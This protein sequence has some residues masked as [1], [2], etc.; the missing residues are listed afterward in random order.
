[1]PNIS[2]GTRAVMFNAVKSNYTNM[3]GYAYS[4]T[5]PATGADPATGTYLGAV[6]LNGGAFTPGNAA[7]GLNFEVVNGELRKPPADVWRLVPT[8][9][10]RIGYI[11]FCANAGTPSTQ[12]D[13]E[14]RLDYTYGTNGSTAEL[15]GATAD[16]EVGVPLTVDT[17]VNRWKVA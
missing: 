15:R 3:V 17:L 8:A 7:N 16:V 10:G 14:H 13:T 2:P 4:G 11:R 12:S 5:K 1:M 6:T 9:A